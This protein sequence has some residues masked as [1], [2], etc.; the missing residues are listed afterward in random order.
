MNE[1]MTHNDLENALLFWCLTY[2]SF[3]SFQF[4]FHFRP[5]LLCRSIGLKL[6]RDELVVMVE[7]ELSTTRISSHLCMSPSS[8]CD[9]E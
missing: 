2:G 4:L 9:C 6:L 3:L 1:V 7:V 5:N 8:D